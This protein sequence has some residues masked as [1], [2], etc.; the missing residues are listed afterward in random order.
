[1]LLPILVATNEVSV[2]RALMCWEATTPSA[3]EG[4]ATLPPE[5]SSLAHL[6]QLSYQLELA[7][8]PL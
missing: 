3:T 4:E 6:R 5:Q 7:S 8:H 1:M 2:K